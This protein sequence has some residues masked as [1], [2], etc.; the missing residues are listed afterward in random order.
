M[1]Y[2]ITIACLSLK[3]LKSLKN[4]KLLILE[5]PAKPLYV[6]GGEKHLPH[7]PESQSHIFL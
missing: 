6:T 5:A 3:S 7:K 1:V 2:K 4:K